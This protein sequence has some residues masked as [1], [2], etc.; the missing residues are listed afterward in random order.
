MD[1]GP[2]R[3]SLAKATIRDAFATA[4]IEPGGELAHVGTAIMSSEPASGN[5]NNS[6]PV[7][8][9][10]PFQVGPFRAM[11]GYNWELHREQS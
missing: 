4:D 5:A 8:F 11:A 9:G 2:P 1:Q 6:A 10:T 3:T 7:G